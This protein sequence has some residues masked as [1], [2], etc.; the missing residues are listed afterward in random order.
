MDESAS[1]PVTS[2]E[3]MLRL[4]GVSGYVVGDVVEAKHRVG[5]W[6]FCTIVGKTEGADGDIYQVFLLGVRPHCYASPAAAAAHC[7]APAPVAWLCASDAC[8][9]LPGQPRDCVPHFS[10]V[11]WADG[12]TTDTQKKRS[13][14]RACD[15]ERSRAYFEH[16]QKKPLMSESFGVWE[17]TVEDGTRRQRKAVEPLKHVTEHAKAA[18]AANGSKTAKAAKHAWG[19]AGPPTFSAQKVLSPDV[20]VKHITYGSLKGQ[21]GGFAAR[22]IKPGTVVSCYAGKLSLAS[23][24]RQEAAD[25]LVK[26]TVAQWP[27]ERGALRLPVST[28][29]PLAAPLTLRLDPSP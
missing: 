29:R 10:Q 16:I 7:A 5:G 4:K 8:L 21:A 24:L 11:K 19:T 26:E 6:H 15:Q 27:P 14:I 18:E 22:D 13:A 23:T 9:L 12:D 3:E 17:G 28:P 2:F 20:V 25:M 1:G